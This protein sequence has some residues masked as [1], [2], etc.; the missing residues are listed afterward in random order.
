ME[1]L[2]CCEDSSTELPRRGA[3]CVP[4]CTLPARSSLWELGFDV[5]HSCQGM[6]FTALHLQLSVIYS[7]LLELYQETFFS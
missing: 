4:A 3:L 6:A 5:A 1:V 2:S 7:P